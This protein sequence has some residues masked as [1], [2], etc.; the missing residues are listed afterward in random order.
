[1][2]QKNAQNGQYAQAGHKMVPEK[3]R[4]TYIAKNWFKM[5]S[6]KKSKTH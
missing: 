4:N 6:G 5:V 3:G 1:M 2:V